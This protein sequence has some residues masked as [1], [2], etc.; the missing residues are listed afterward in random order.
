MGREGSGPYRWRVGNPARTPH[1]WSIVVA[2]IAAIDI[3]VH[4]SFLVLVVLF[5]VAAPEPGP[6]GV[7]WSLVWLLVIFGSV[8]VHELAHCVVARTR[9]ADVHE[10]LLFPLGG[11]SKLDRLPE[12]PRDEFAVAVVGPLASLGI[13]AAAAALC[14]VTGRDLLPFDLLTGAW[15]ERIAWL[16]VILGG[17]NLLPAFPLDGGRVFRSLLE[18]HRDLLSATRVATRTG[19]VLA[20]VLVAIGVLFDPWL[21]LIGVFVYVG[22]SAEEAATIVHVRLQGHRVGELMRPGVGGPAGPKR[23]AGTTLDADT[24]LDIDVVARL[25]E[26]Q[27][28][29]TV[30]SDGHE[31][32]ELRLDDVRRF[33]AG[34]QTPPDRG[35]G[36]KRE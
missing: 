16:N 27:G 34:Q 3:R 12:T 33:V 35:E 5:A 10:I 25:Q 24:P 36:A 23:E 15:L 21:V 6:I 14:V 29:A 18:R 30:V 31:V 8:V 2:R 22:A 28:V 11:I 20:G 32:G 17:F 19:H 7:L 9:G 1:R 26:A 13:G 4:V